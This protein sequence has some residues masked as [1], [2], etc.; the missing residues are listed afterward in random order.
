MK[1]P[2][3]WHEYGCDCEQCKVELAHLKAWQEGKLEETQVI[4]YEV[5]IVQTKTERLPKQ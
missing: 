3:W 5:V 1:Q 4:R 2:G